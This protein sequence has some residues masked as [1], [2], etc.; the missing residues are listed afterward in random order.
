MVSELTGGVTYKLYACRSEKN[1]KLPLGTKVEA[2]V[3]KTDL[4]K[5]NMQIS[6]ISYKNVDTAFDTDISKFMISQDEIKSARSGDVVSNLKIDVKDGFTSIN[7]E[8]LRVFSRSKKIKNG[9]N[10][11]YKNALVW[12]YKGEKELVVE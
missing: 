1:P 11:V 3:N 8:K 4:Y 7:G 2:I 9:Q 5:G 6:S 10:L 12:S